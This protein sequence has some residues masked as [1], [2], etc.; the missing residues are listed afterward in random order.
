MA[1]IAGSVTNLSNGIF[2]VKDENGNVRVLKVGDKI[3]ENDTVFGDNG[4]SSSSRLEILLSGNDVIVLSE[5]QEQLIDSS[6]I[7]TAFGTEELFFTRESIDSKLENQDFDETVF[8]D[9]ENVDITEEETAAGEEQAEED[10]DISAFFNQRSADTTN[11]TSD[12]RDAQFNENIQTFEN[13][14][15]EPPALVDT[16]ISLS[17]SATI[18]ETQLNLVYT[19]TLTNPS[20]GE[21]KVTL[22]NGSVIIIAN[23]E[24]TGNITVSNPNTEDVYKDES[25]ISV[26]ITEVSG[27]NFDNIIIDKTPTI[28]TV[29]DSIDT[30]NFTLNSIVINNKNTSIESANEDGSIIIY[31]VTFD[32]APTQD[33]IVS[34]TV[35][36]VV[37]TITVKAGSTTGTTQVNYEDADVYIDPNTIPSPSDLTSTNN[38]NY[39]DL[40]AVNNAS[41]ITIEDSIDTTTVSISASNVT[42]DEDSITFTIQTSNPLDEGTSASATVNINGTIY[43]VDLNENGKGILTIDTKDSD[44]I[45]EEDT[46]IS[47]TVESINGGNFENIDLNGATFVSTVSDTEDTTTVTVGNVSANEDATQATVSVKLEGHD[48]RDNETVTVTLSDGTEVEFT[49]NTS[50]DA[51]FTFTAN[52]DSIV[53]TDTSSDISATLV[54]NEGIIE[55]PVVNKGTLTLSDTED[56]TTVSL[57][58]TKEILEDATPEL[59]DGTSG[60]ADLTVRYTATLTAEAQNTITVTLDNGETIIIEPKN[61]ILGKDD[62]G[63]DI[64]SDGLTGFIDVLIPERE[65][66][67]DTTDGDDVYIEDDNISATITSVSEENA[68]SSNSFEALVIEKDDE[69][70]VIPAVTTILDDKDPVNATITAIATAPHIVNVD[71]IFDDTTGVTISAFNASGSTGTVSVVSGTNHDGFGVKGSSSGAA[72]EIGYNNNLGAS[73]K[74]IFDFDNEVNSL[75]VAFAWRNP[76]ETAVV[77]FYDGETEIGYAVISGGSSTDDTILANLSYYNTNG[78]LLKSIAVTGG[79]DTVDEPYTFEFPASVNSSEILSFNKVEFSAEGRGDD[80]LINEISFTETVDA[81]ISDLETSGGSATFIVQLDYVPQTAGTTTAIIDINDIEYTV[82]VNN[83]GRATVTLDSS[84]LG[85]LSNVVVKLISVTGG[86]YEAINLGDTVR[87]DFSSEEVVSTDDSII[88]IEDTTY[89]LTENDFGVLDPD[90]TDIKITSLPDNGVL[91]YTVTE[92][93][94]SIGGDGETTVVTAAVKNAITIDDVN[95]IISLA[96]ITAGKLEFEPNTNTDEDGK[97]EFQVG[98]NEGNFS[99]ESYE[100][101]IEVIAVADAPEASIN[102]TK[103]ESSETSN[104]LIIKLDDYEYNID[105]IIGNKGD[106]V[107]YEFGNK[108]DQNYNMNS[109]NN[110][111]ITDTMGITGDKFVQ[112]NSSENIIIIDGDFGKDENQAKINANNGNDLI[113]IT[114]DII[115]GDIGDSSGNADVIYINKSSEYFEYDVASNHTDNGFG[116]G[117]DG[118]ITQYADLDHQI[119]I[120]S[121][122]VNNIEGVLFSDGGTFGTVTKVGDTTNTVE[123]N[124]DLSAALTDIDGSETLTVIIGNVPTDAVLSSEDYTL[125]KN[126]D[127]TW[128]VTVAENE[129][130]INITDIKMIVPEGTL[131]VDLTITA[132]ATENYENENNDN[133]KE[134]TNSNALVDINIDTSLS[135]DAIT[136]SVEPSSLE[137][138]DVKDDSL[139]SEDSTQINSVNDYWTNEE[140]ING[141][142]N[143][144]SISIGTGNEKIINAGNGNDIVITPSSFWKG[145]GHIINGG[146]GEDIL[147]IE[148]NKDNGELRFDIIENT[149]NTY[150]IKAINYNDNGNEWDAGYELTVDSIETIQFKDITISLPLNT[151]NNV[152]PVAIINDESDALLD[153]VD[154]N[155]I[156]TSTSDSSQ[157]FAVFDE[158][159]NIKTV[160][161]N[162]SGLLSSSIVS[163]ITTELVFNLKEDTDI[164]G[165]TISNEGES[166]I[167]ITANEEDGVSSTQ[168]NELL[169]NIQIEYSGLTD[170][171]AQTNVDLFTNLTLTV[172]DSQGL[173]DTEEKSDILVANI[174]TNDVTVESS[175]SIMSLDLGISFDNITQIENEEESSNS[176]NPDSSKEE[177]TLIDDVLE[178]DNSI[179][180]LESEDEKELS[181][182]PTEKSSSESTSDSS[183]YSE[184]STV[185]V[186]VEQPISDGITS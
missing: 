93:V 8:N 172:I 149:D 64:L 125:T 184:D 141:T 113:I 99:N 49:E 12:L 56:T 185:Q 34:F 74:I 170:D 68:G 27:G 70:E 35:D 2:S 29:N 160:T 91:Y 151:S 146:D 18:T 106:F 167:T 61:T 169:S 10:S 120:G 96:N 11:I 122:I 89:V 36:G 126:D 158:D 40:N 43:T 21:T 166:S 161:I 42:E 157:I 53:E 24:T 98:N 143:S 95:N 139:D 57:S 164:S 130:S 112:G 37:N 14:L 9:V 23:G 28:T 110:V 39:E 81:S 175:Q 25:T 186:K 76:G 33:E 135:A 84:I 179:A 66:I 16:I 115:N 32:T 20:K 174:L 7:E 44:S 26:S 155:L 107:Q 6:L 133:F 59:G 47:A 162:S 152:A 55:N 67:S 52:S 30:T 72:T 163:L 136:A 132:R 176:E 116:T 65:N 62:T 45:K 114:G 63:V 78:T 60:T 173:E 156:S 104:S 31:T 129:T 121:M 85:D 137:T 177:K 79:T 41:E 105:E 46:L 181:T 97:F 171:L 92:A 50:K 153:L 168:F 22:D 100:I 108:N 83:S 69:G 71:T 119:V 118:T 90:V 109:V 58:A 82:N 182:L 94:T 86:N 150:T 15:I 140:V 77:T 111:T 88:A 165:F 73:E 124:I 117:I 48:F 19:A 147:V 101:S 144:D 75:D 54:S 145:T 87:F 128:E 102:V 1:I 142:E 180:G 138:Q 131:N 134:T 5:G 154:T 178:S 4:N 80:Y 51:T 159:E 183:A 127:N 123:Y 3:Y 103:L 13:D 38:S 148:H 17:A